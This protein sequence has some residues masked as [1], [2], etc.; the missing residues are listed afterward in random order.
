VFHKSRERR[1][2]LPKGQRSLTT[3]QAIVVVLE[4]IPIARSRSDQA[5]EG[6]RT[7]DCAHTSR[8]YTRCIDERCVTLAHRYTSGY[9]RA[10]QST[11]TAVFDAHFHIV[12]PAY[13]LI[14][15][16]G[17]LPDAFTADDYVAR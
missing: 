16:N 8:V 7:I 14:P 15:N 9:S 1:V 12:D 17:F 3:E 4:V 6:V 13:P 11:D 5:E 2:D 10:M